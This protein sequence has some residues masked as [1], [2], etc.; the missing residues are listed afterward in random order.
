MSSYVKKNALENVPRLDLPKEP[1]HEKSL[2][3]V[4]ECWDLRLDTP[5]SASTVSWGVSAQR[6]PT[7]KL[8][9]SRISEDQK[10]TCGINS[11]RNIDKLVLTI[12][13]FFGNLE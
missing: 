1:E 12:H 7:T 10:A 8:L 9:T 5:G 4:A 3:N 11:N 13:T 2:L 6:T